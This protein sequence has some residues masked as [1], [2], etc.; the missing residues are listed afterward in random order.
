MN[1]VFLKETHDASA[2]AVGVDLFSVF[3]LKWEKNCKDVLNK[4][5]QQ[6]LQFL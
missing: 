1:H 6:H 5:K 3:F 4:A 2:H